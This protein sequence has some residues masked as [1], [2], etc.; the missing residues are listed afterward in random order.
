MYL[1]CKG[2]LD[3]LVSP[4]VREQHA[5]WAED[6]EAQIREGIRARASRGWCGGSVD[7]S[8]GGRE[9]GAQAWVADIAATPGTA[10]ASICWASASTLRGT[11]VSLP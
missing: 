4:E 1:Q 9:G 3:S 10:S 7:G 5:M 11:L 6:M 2:F 8:V